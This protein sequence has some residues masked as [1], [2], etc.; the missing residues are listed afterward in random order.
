METKYLRLT[1]N[2]RTF[3]QN[4]NKSVWKMEGYQGLEIRIGLGFAVSNLSLSATML[5]LN[6]DRI[7]SVD[8]NK[9]DDNAP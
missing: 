2:Q 5:K 7:G 1:K 4:E 8:L 3:S 9:N 6:L